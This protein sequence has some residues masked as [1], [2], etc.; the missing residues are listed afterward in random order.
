MRLDTEAAADAMLGSVRHLT[1]RLQRVQIRDDMTFAEREAMGLLLQH[2]PATSAELARLAQISPQAMGTTLAVLESRQLVQRGRDPHDGRRV[3][4]SCTQE[5]AQFVE[6][7]RGVRA[8]IVA[9]TLVK[10]FTVAEIEVLAQAAPL[11]ER[12]AQRI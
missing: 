3:V 12:L 8:Q 5:G 1:R 9:D 11:L 7:S 4:F 10:H 6:N 2:G